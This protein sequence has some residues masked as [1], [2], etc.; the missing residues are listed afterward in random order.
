MLLQL[1]LFQGH[2]RGDFAQILDKVKLHF[3]KHKTGETIIESKTPCEQLCFLLK[4]K[5]SIITT[6]ENGN[7][8]VV[9]RIAAPYVIEPQSLFGMNTTFA[10]TYV[11][12]EE[13]HTVSISKGL[14]LNELFRYEIF[15]L[16]YMNM[17]C[18]RT[19]NLYARLWKEAKQ[20]MRG[21][22]IFFFAIHCEKTQGEKIFR[23]KKEDLAHFLSTTRASASRMLN[24]LQTEGLLLLKRKEIIIPDMQ[25]LLNTVR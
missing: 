23:M 6:S 9:E 24:E 19:Q 1:P 25:K 15:R 17:V 12:E 5:V 10:S 8:T 18:N 7:Y 16:N 11:A 20:T 4:G 14:V 22:A 13:T 3:C 2:C 21:K